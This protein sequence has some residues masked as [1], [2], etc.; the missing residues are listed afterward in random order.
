MFTYLKSF[1]IQDF[2]TNFNLGLQLKWCGTLKASPNYSCNSRI[3]DDFFLVYISSG[4]GQFRCNKKRYPLK[5]GSLFFLFPGVLHS[6]ETDASDLLCQWW[7][8]FNGYN[9]K[10]I[11][12][13]LDIDKTNPIITI[14]SKSD[15]ESLIKRVVQSEIDNTPLDVLTQTGVLYNIFGMISSNRIKASYNRDSHSNTHSN[16]DKAISFMESNYNS[17]ISIMD[18]A[19]YVSMS[20]SYF[21][22]TFKKEVGVTPNEYI[23]LLQLKQAKSLI[24]NTKL[25]IKEVSK[26]VGF[27]DPLYFSKF[28]KKH[29]GFSPMDFRGKANIFGYS[30]NKSSL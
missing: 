18:I 24:Q 7:L 14:E 13:R 26:L 23:K 22:S 16:I 21:Y 1:Y 4:S 19:D 17:K 8:G 10:E 2:N 15:I 12:E 30:Q 5:K 25:S 27:D 9:V 29:T 28:F 6:Y 3:M 20:K 11:L